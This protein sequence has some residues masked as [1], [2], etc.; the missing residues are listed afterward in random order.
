MVNRTLRRPYTQTNGS[1]DGSAQ[2]SG[3]ESDTDVV[4][5]G[6][7]TDVDSSSNGN[8]QNTIGESDSAGGIGYVTIDPNNIDFG[9]VARDTANND[10]SYSTRKRRSDAGQKRGTRGP[11]KTDKTASLS[12]LFLLVDTW[13]NALLKIPELEL[14]EKERKGLTDALDNFE[15]YHEIPMLSAK[16]Q[17]EINLILAF[18]FA[19]VPRIGLINKRMQHEARVKKARNVTPFT[20]TQQEHDAAVQ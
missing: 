18:G 11:R 5:S 6:R 17:S 15:K 1:S 20:A 16:R 13:A 9:A 7:D 2:V 8:D 12:S 19:Y 14:D 4:E 10:G 3:V